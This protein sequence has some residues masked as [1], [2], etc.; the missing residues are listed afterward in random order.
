MNKLKKGLII[1]AAVVVAEKV[2]DTIGSAIIESKV[3][4]LK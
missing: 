3:E 1:L 2:I 4:K